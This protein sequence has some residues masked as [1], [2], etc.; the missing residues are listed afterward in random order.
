MNG[1]TYILVCD[2]DFEEPIRIGFG[3]AGERTLPPGLYAYVGSAQGPGGFSRLERH[4]EISLGNRSVRHW[5]IDYLLG[6]SAVT[7]AER[8][9]LPGADCEC[10]L[11]GVLSG[12]CIP[13]IGASDCGCDTHLLHIGRL[14]AVRDAVATRHH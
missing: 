6:H 1:G 2:L 7:I 8:F 12:E 14:K 3:A 4:R 9:T 5:H 11:A 13:G 10:E